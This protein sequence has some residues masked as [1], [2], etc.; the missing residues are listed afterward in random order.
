VAT[1]KI[2]HLTDIIILVCCSLSLLP[3]LKDFE[4]ECWEFESLRPHQQYQRFT[5]FYIF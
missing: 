1:V 2:H 5:T 4:S 3:T